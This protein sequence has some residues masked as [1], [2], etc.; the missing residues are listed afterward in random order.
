M[1]FSS[2][3]RKINRTVALWGPVVFWAALIFYFSSLPHLRTE[4]GWIDFVL[5]KL[6]HMVEYGIL[7]LL[8]VRGLKGSTGCSQGSL[9]RISFI[10]SLLYALSDEF[11][12]SFVSGRNGSVWDVCI[13]G[14]G[15]VFAAGAYTKI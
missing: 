4:L 3:T 12:Q 5:R 15:M 6:A 11:H 2:E 1:T 7:W 13:D 9:L 8:L 10:V 14:L